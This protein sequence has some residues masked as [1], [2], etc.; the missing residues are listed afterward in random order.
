MPHKFHIFFAY[1]EHSRALRYA[2]DRTWRSIVH[3]VMKDPKRAKHLC[4]ALV[5]NRFI[6]N[7][8]GTVAN[9]YEH[10]DHTT[11]FYAIDIDNV[12]K[13]ARLIKKELFKC[14][15]ELRMVWISSSGKGVKAIGYSDKLKNLNTND[16]KYQY[17]LTCIRLR[18]QVGMALN[19][20][21]TSGR[22]HQPVFLNRDSRAL[23]RK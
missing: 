10:L 8:D 23:V 1:S 5:L 9:K 19:F 20:D 22:P 16:Y 14:C 12:G 3:A 13:L 21:Y 4:P 18:E 6:P 11:G 15:P 17:K 2:Y 7:V